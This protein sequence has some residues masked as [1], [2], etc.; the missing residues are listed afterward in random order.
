MKG[1]IMVLILIILVSFLFFSLYKGYFSFYKGYSS[2]KNFVSNQTF[3][4]SED[5]FFKYEILKYPTDVEIIKPEPRKQTSI[6]IVVDPYNLRFGRIP[7]GGNSVNRYVVLVNLQEKKAKVEFNVF[8]DISPMVSFS[9]NNFLLNA[10]EN[11]TVTVLLS[12]TE[13][14][15]PGNYSGEIDVVTKRPKYDFLYQILGWV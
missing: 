7:T 2:P 10:Y 12:T 14:T 13:T 5:T 4:R 6:G 1:K 15:P 8:G 9:D 3:E 11:V